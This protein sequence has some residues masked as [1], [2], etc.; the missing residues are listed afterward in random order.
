MGFA[1]VVCVWCWLVCRGCIDGSGG[2]VRE[3][4]WRRGVVLVIVVVV[5]Q[6]DVVVVGVVRGV[7]VA[8]G[9][10]RVMLWWEAW[11]GLG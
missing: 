5:I 8:V 2:V 1:N 6:C 7:V 4:V 3:V 11:C 10:R 9:R